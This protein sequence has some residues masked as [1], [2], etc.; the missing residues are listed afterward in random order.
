MNENLEDTPELVNEEP[1]GSGWL[2]R[3][4]PS[5]M[6]EWDALLEVDAYKK[7]VEEEEG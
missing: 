3:I 2:V 5:D 7:V 6:D 1:F 4:A